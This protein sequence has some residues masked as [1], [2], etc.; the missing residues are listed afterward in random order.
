MKY[1]NIEKPKPGQEGPS[2][3]EVP[4]VKKLR[5]YKIIIT[6]VVTAGR[7]F[8]AGLHPA[9]SDAISDSVPARGASSRAAAEG[10]QGRAAGRGRS[11]LDGHFT[12]LLIDEAAQTTEC[13]A[14][15]ALSLAGPNTKVIMFGDHMQMAAGTASESADRLRYTRSLLARLFPTRTYADPSLPSSLCRC[16]LRNNYRSHPQL[17]LLSKHL[18]YGH[19]VDARAIDVPLLRFPP[20]SPTHPSATIFVAVRHVRQL[21]RSPRAAGTSEDLYKPAGAI[22]SA[23]SGHADFL[24]SP[25]AVAVVSIVQ[26]LLQSPGITSPEDIAVVTPYRS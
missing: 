12:H 18:V 5:Q 25:E 10:G 13:N 2:E 15:V 1:A 24:N 11:P 8:S 23:M 7:L 22:S 6:T 20:S 19:A 16:E 21:S 4:P 9:R 17:I 26:Q 3:L 14:S